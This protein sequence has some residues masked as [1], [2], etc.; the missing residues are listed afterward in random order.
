MLRGEL[1][2]VSGAI[3]GARSTPLVPP[4]APARPAHGGRSARSMRAPRSTGAFIGR[5]P[6]RPPAIGARS[7]GAPICSFIPL[8]ALGGRSFRNR[9]L[10]CTR[11]A[12]N[13]PF[14]RSPC[15]AS[16][17]GP[18]SGR[19]FR[20][21]AVPSLIAGRVR[22]PAFGAGV[23][24][25][26]TVRSRTAAGGTRIARTPPKRLC[27]VGF[28]STRLS[29]RAFRSAFPGTRS[30]ARSTRCPPA[31]TFRGTAVTAPA[32]CA[33]TKFTLRMFV[34]RMLMLRIRVLR[35]LMFVMNVRLQRNH[36][37]N[38]SPNPSGNH[39]TGAPNPNPKKLEC[40]NE[41]NDT[42]AGA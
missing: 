23:A 28:T 1:P 3:R 39:A 26:T 21:M 17:A 32:T 20:A 16:G 11:G 41:T 29:K 36:G 25:D 8:D 7:T 31:N 37:K 2:R 40:P 14:G 42:N 19:P 15:R 34:L 24:R 6:S 13:R 22:N 27:L 18:G 4:G 33:F 10:G 9:S 12:P 5:A 35:M 38:G 30:A